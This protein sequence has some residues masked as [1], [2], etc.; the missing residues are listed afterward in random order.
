VF[1]TRPV[2]AADKAEWLRLLRGLHP[3]MPESAHIPSIDA[4]LAGEPHDSLLP[5]AVFVCERPDGRLAGFLELSVR[6]YAENCA[7][8]T[9]YVES[10]YVD[11]DVRKKGLGRALM[12]AAE[13]WARAAGYPEMASD[14]V[15]E[16]ELSHRA[17]KAVG[18]DEVQRVV[19][20]RKP[21]T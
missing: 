7:G 4:F 12:Q 1:E 21:L 14:A 20:F 18:F 15:L 9:P 11:A 13:D 6:N 3:E 2:R 8:A 17:H 16:N 10:W 5:V 19:V